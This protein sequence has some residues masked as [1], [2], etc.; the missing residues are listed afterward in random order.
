M[1]P[2]EERDQRILRER[3][4]FADWVVNPSGDALRWERELD[5]LLEARPRGLGSVLSLGCGRGW[6]E[7]RLAE[8]ADL[9]LGIDLSP[10]S[11][12]EASALAARQGL[13]RVEFICADITAFDFDREF[14][15]ILCVGFLHHLSDADAL[16]LLT[17]IRRHLREGGLVHTQD[18]NA[19]GILRKIGRLVLGARYD[20]YHTE[21]ERE[22]D[23]D[24]VRALFVEAGFEKT[25]L[26]YMDLSLIP[27]MQLFPSAPAW[28]MAGFAGLDRLFCGLPGLAR[29]SSGFSVDA[30]R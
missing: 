13:D 7:T 9:V 25:R 26:R 22:L 29:W 3:D 24:R 28:V 14:D 12:D 10:D 4:F 5:L 21:D 27:A 19:R 18:P 1:Q 8:H 2:D 23:P 16:A 6:F 17:R 15:T 20:A 11:I 30:T